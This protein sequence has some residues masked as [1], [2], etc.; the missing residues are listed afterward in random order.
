M[1]SNAE[2]QDWNVIEEIWER[3][4]ME[5]LGQMIRGDEQPEPSTPIEQPL[6]LFASSDDRFAIDN[7]EPFTDTTLKIMKIISGQVDQVTCFTSSKF[8]VW[9]PQVV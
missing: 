2:D 8:V 3:N 1:W 6:H 4:Q 7:T 9:I 5:N